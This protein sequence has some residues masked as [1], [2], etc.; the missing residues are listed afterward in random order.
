MRILAILS[1]L[2]FVGCDTSHEFG[3]TVHHRV[4]IDTEGIADL[5]EDSCRKE[6]EGMGLKGRHADDCTKAC[7]AEYVRDF[8]DMVGER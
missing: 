4:G 3:G 1:M 7:I 8:L 6:C 5:F 2:L